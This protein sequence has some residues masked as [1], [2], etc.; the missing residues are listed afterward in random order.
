MQFKDIPQVMDLGDLLILQEDLDDI[1]APDSPRAIDLTQIGLC[2]LG[3]PLTFPE[4]HC[5]C[6]T[7]TRT[8]RP[9]F[10][11][12]KDEAVLIPENQVDFSMCCPI[13]RCQ[14]S[15]ASRRQVFPCRLFAEMT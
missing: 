3:N 4:I 2:C 10:D 15:H 14:E 9:G 8:L 13:V 12:D 11:F 6:R 1:E 5:E 7:C